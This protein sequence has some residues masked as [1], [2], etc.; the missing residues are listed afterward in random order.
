MGC[1]D[2]ESGCTDDITIKLLA[3]QAA[4]TKRADCVESFVFKLAAED[5]TTST[6][7]S[8]EA[9]TRRLV[10]TARRLDRSDDDRLRKALVEIGVP[11]ERVDEGFAKCGVTTTTTVA[12]TTSAAPTSAAP[13]T[14]APAA[15]SEA[16]P[17]LLLRMVKAS[18]DGM[19]P[20]DKQVC[21]RDA[22]L[23]ALP[24][25]ENTSIPTPASITKD[26]LQQ[27]L[28]GLGVSVQQ[29]GELL[30]ECMMAA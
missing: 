3:V 12:P 21:Y 5:T 13:T 16:F 17:D 2:D 9:F 26:T 11:A 14:S 29:Q 24:D 8:S 15:P 10:A 25:G 20:P 4:G 28:A 22:L 27:V 19:V 30:G 18:T 1:A 6:P 23:G 7:V